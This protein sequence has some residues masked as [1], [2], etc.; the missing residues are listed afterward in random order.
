MIIA[1]LFERFILN[2]AKPKEYD[3]YFF[4]RFFYFNKKSRMMV[5]GESMTKAPFASLKRKA[6]TTLP[7]LP[8]RPMPSRCS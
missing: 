3:S 4:P 8:F 2:R 5:F 7:V 1:V 6:T